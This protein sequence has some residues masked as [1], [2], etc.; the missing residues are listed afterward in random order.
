LALALTKLTSATLIHGGLPQSLYDTSRKRDALDV[1]ARARLV[2]ATM[3]F[4][5]AG[6]SHASFFS[7]S[8]FPT[9]KSGTGR[10]MNP[11]V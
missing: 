3:V 4:Q 11:G 10:F 2:R 6:S 8:S 5:S 7:G 9:R 1:T